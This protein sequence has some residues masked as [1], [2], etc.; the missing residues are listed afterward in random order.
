MKWHSFGNF[1]PERGPFYVATIGIRGTFTST[2]EWIIDEIDLRSG[3][4][5]LFIDLL[6]LSL[7]PHASTRQSSVFICFTIYSL[8]NK[9][10]SDMESELL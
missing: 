8:A 10:L 7:V 2:G 3:N 9:L 5:I 4:K 1:L 6:F